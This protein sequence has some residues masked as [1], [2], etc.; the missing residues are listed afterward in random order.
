MNA[1]EVCWSGPLLMHISTVVEGAPVTEPMAGNGLVPNSI[2]PLGPSISTP[3]PKLPGNA[4]TGLLPRGPAG[5]T[6]TPKMAGTCDVGTGFEKK[7]SMVWVAEVA[8]ATVVGW[9]T[10]P[11]PKFTVVV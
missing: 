7:K 11:F 6:P 9:V 2:T 10:I 1:P 3:W 5:L 8:T 4:V